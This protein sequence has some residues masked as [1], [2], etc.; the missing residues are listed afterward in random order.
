MTACVNWFEKTALARQVHAYFAFEHGIRAA[1]RKWYRGDIH[2]FSRMKQAAS[3]DYS[4]MLDIYD[5][6]LIDF[7]T[8]GSDLELATERQDATPKPTTPAGEQV[9]SE[10]VP[11]RAIESATR[12]N[13]SPA[14]RVAA[15]TQPGPP[16]PDSSLDRVVATVEARIKARQKRQPAI[17]ER[18]SPASDAMESTLKQD[19]TDSELIE[20]TGSSELSQTEP[21]EFDQ[22]GM[23]QTASVL[24]NLLEIDLGWRQGHSI[25]VAKFTE[26][27]AAQI[28]LPSNDIQHLRWAALLHELGK[29]AEHHLTALSIDSS[30]THRTVAENVALTPL[31]LLEAVQLPAIVIQALGALYERP[32]G[33]G[34]PGRL[35]DEKIP[36]G[37]RILSTVDAFCDLMN[38]PRAS[39]GRAASQTEALNRI[40]QA[41]QAGLL[42]PRVCEAFA[43]L[44]NADTLQSKLL[45]SR[46]RL[47]LIDGD[48]QGSSIIELQLVAEGFA[49]RVVRTTAEAA[50][51]VLS[52]TVDLILSEVD[53]EPVNGF[54]FLQRIRS[55]QR[56]ANV[57]LIFISAIDAADQISRASELGALDYL[58]KPFTTDFLVR[59]I[60]RA[61]NEAP[62]SSGAVVDGRL[63]EMALAE[64]LQI[65][66]AGK[67]TGALILH[68][69][70]HQGRVYVEGGEVIEATYDDKN[71]E[72]ALRTLLH[73]NRGHFTYD[74]NVELPSRTIHKTTE[75]L[76]YE[77]LHDRD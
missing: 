2:A 52:G 58:V 64:I 42:D 17:G 14:S 71:G 75:T 40:S 45:G 21:A 33:K 23:Q 15:T 49:A 29:P 38:N 56:T 20:L 12:P 27:L 5:Q 9:V 72:L 32:D 41:S 73:L 48:V 70:D 57:P 68:E 11:G 34:I 50:R 77:A 76:V 46:P 53:L 36:M 22:G 61:L 74:P 31:R 19:G 59:R 60:R 26:L 54:G 37:A 25:E 24:V 16:P 51:E 4:R 6:R 62:A 8:G 35:R 7:D 10:D 65:W 47:L 13:R 1:I 69:A 39:E 43:N 63:E 3:E 55:D 67:K 44:M 18:V 30:A 28:G 66:G